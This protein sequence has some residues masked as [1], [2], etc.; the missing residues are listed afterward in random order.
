M[1]QDEVRFGPIADTRHIIVCRRPDRP[2]ASAMV[3]QQA[4]G[5]GAV[6]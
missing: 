3:T 4:Y 1:F 2:M 5:Y 6:S